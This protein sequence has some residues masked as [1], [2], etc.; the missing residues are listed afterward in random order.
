MRHFADLTGAILLFSLTGCQATPPSVT[1]RGDTD[2]TA[3]FRYYE[4]GDRT[5]ELTAYDAEGA[6]L[7][8][9]HL[10]WQGN[11]GIEWKGIKLYVGHSYK[12]LAADASTNT[13]LWAQDVWSIHPGY[14]YHL[15][16]TFQ[17]ITPP[18]GN[19][20]WAVVTRPIRADGHVDDT[21][22]MI[23]YN[24]L[25]TGERVIPPNGHP[26][27]KG[28]EFRT[29]R[30]Y[31]DGTHSISKPFITIITRESDWQRLLARCAVNDGMFVERFD[32]NTKLG[33]INFN[34]EVVLIRSIERLGPFVPFEEVQTYES[35][36]R[37]LLRTQYSGQFFVTDAN[38]HL[39]D[40]TFYE[41]RIF[42]LPKRSKAAYI[43]QE[44]INGLIGSSSVW[45]EIY[46]LDRLGDADRELDALLAE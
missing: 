21:E 45:S 27:P 38:E 13:M 11:R 46:R 12:L 10:R 33:L 8:N 34:N 7:K 42:V 36:D 6:V 15:A 37:I 31:A 16:V 18:A 28:V 44:D 9:N 25:H 23:E 3:R 41:Y 2:S 4:P 1:I 14:K 17:R 24:N 29:R 5:L 19:P 26:K 22:D 35:D 39:L 40:K 20:I 43:L 30:A 32:L